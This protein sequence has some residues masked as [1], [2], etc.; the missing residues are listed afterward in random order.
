M[1]E[2]FE[3][4]APAVEH[5]RAALEPSAPVTREYRGPAFVFPESIPAIGDTILATPDDFEALGEHFA[6]AIEEWRD[7]Q[8]VT[9]VLEDGVAVSIC[10]SPATTAGASEAGVFTAE[11]ARG[12]GHAVAVVS[13][14]AHAVRDLGRLPL[15]STTWE[16]LASRRVAAK[17]GLEQYGED[18][19][20]D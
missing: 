3:A 7:I 18:L 6:W 11:S 12:R 19:N 15:Y 14:W 10:H 17:L 5:Y 8:P 9:V 4:N 2:D 1:V 13:R 16:N 20:L